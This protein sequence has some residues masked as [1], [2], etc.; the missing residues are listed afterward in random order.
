MHP[1]EYERFVNNIRRT[2]IIHVGNK[3]LHD[4]MQDQAIGIA[5]WAT[6]NKYDEASRHVEEKK[7]HA[8][9]YIKTSVLK[10]PWV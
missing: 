4:V 5:N 8:I 6:S 3:T 10:W 9:H 1:E 2:K 7:Q